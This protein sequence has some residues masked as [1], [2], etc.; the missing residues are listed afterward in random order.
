MALPCSVTDMNNFREVIQTFGGAKAL[1]DLTGIKECTVRQWAARDSIPAKHWAVIAD[2][3][4]D[5]RYAGITYAA[6]GKLAGRV[7]A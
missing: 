1:S 7:R 2:T 3:A 4:R 5:R 6:L